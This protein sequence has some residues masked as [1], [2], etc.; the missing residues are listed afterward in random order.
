MKK[1][2][3]YSGLTS[4][5]ASSILYYDE[6]EMESFL[7]KYDAIS[8]EPMV[9][10]DGTFE[11]FVSF[12]RKFNGFV[13]DPEKRKKKII[14]HVRQIAET[15]TNADDREQFLLWFEAVVAK[16]VP[17]ELSDGIF[18]RFVW[19]EYTDAIERINSSD[20][21]FR[22]KLSLRPVALQ[23][24]FN[25]NQKIVMIGDVEFSEDDEAEKLYGTGLSDLDEIVQFYP[26]SFAV[27]A[28]R[29]GVGKTLFMLNQALKCAESGAKCLF[30]SLEMSD[31]KLTER[32][33]NNYQN[34]NIR[35]A[36]KEYDGKTGKYVLN[37]K[38]FKKEMDSIRKSKGFK[39]ISNNLGIYISDV[40]SAESILANIEDEIKKNKYEMVFLD[41]L[42]L[43]RYSH[44]DEWASL[45]KATNALKNLA[46]R[47]NI[48]LVTGSQV[49]RSSKENGLTLEDLFGGSTIEADADQVIG[50]ISA[51]E[52]KQGESSFVYAKVLK[53]RE[54]DLG[55]CKYLVD[56]STGRMELS[57]E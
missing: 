44:L 28:A 32:L 46:F 21:S 20:V 42:Q 54:G 7:L 2:K 13:E 14:E 39:K 12:I 51:R 47:S 8:K 35:E 16:D 18:E 5:L 6:D 11:R 15:I 43:L 4:E 52:R 25:N 38:D 53:N 22:E 41:Y 37:F 24:M 31:K 45:R 55:Q 50:L 29:P 40:S 30:V 36:H 23:E 3:K 1:S 34:M 57:D 33:V 19:E 49:S 26:K 56:Y 17:L 9:V 48:V 10:I 27:V